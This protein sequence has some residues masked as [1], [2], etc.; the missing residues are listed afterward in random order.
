LLGKEFTDEQWYTRQLK[1]VEEHKY[2]T[3][4]ARSS[5]NTQKS[6][7]IAELKITLKELT[8]E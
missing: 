6:L 2:F 4:S 8:R 3:A 7:N 1:F 5:R